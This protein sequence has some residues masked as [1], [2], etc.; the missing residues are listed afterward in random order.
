M[1]AEL[2]KLEAELERRRNKYEVR[3]AAKSEFEKVSIAL[4]LGLTETA[5]T[6]L[7][8]VTETKISNQKDLLVVKRVTEVA[9][10]LGRLATAKKLLIPEAE[11]IT[12]EPVRPEYLDLHLRLAAGRGDYAEADRLLADALRHAWKPPPGQS[13]LDPAILVAPLVGR[14]LLG[15]GQRLT[16]TPSMPWLTNN[17]ADIF[18]RPWLVQ[19]A[20]D[21]WI[22]RWRLEA[23]RNGLL[24]IQQA[25]SN[26]CYA[27]GSP[28]RRETVR[29]H[30]SSFRSSAT[31]PCW[32]TTGL[33]R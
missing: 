8:E 26:T 19:N 24:A 20:S 33:P 5:L 32:A 29:K 17:L 12:D 3:T 9:L 27:A 11:G 31:L 16:G 2:V 18:Q 14:A 4:E 6:S 15:H 10:D 1:S 21:F 28:W 13:L 25:R 30:A 7:E 23:V 22:R